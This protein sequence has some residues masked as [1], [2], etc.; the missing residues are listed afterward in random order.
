MSGVRSSVRERVGAALGDDDVGV[1]AFEERRQREDVAEVVVDDE[2]LRALER[3]VV[4]AVRGDRGRARRASCRSAG[5]VVRRRRGRAARSGGAVAGRDRSWCRRRGA[6]P[7]GRKTVNV[8]PSPGV[9][10]NGDLAAEQADELAADRE[11]ETRCRRRGARS[12]R[13]PARTLRRS[14]CCCS[15]S[16]PMPVSRTA[17]ATHGRRRGRA[18]RS[19]GSSPS[20]ASADLDVHLAV[21]GELERVGEQVLQDLAQALRVGDDRRRGSPV[22]CS[23]EKPSALA[24]AT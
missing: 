8:L 7:T 10:T 3:A 12:C 1:A 21:L 4:E 16:I 20:S 18:T 13:R 22:R 6:G 11:T 17:K 24:W 14:R 19:R 9:L 23:I 2:D 15:S 5:P